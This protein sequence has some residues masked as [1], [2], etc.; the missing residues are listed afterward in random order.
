MTSQF[1][2]FPSIETFAHA[3][4]NQ[5]KRVLTAGVHPVL[6][7]LKIKLH[8]T[9]AAVRI[10]KNGE[11]T[12]Q[13]RKRD[14]TLDFDNYNFCEWVEENRAYFESLAGAEDII[15]Y[16]EWAGPGVQDTD[17]INK[18]D[19]K[20]FFPFAVQ[21]DGKLFTDTYIV[22][23]AFDT[24]LPRPDTIHILPHLAYI[25][26][27]FGRVQSIQDA[28]DEVNEIVEQIAIRDP[29][30]FAKFGIEDAGE[31][32]VGCPIYES[33]VTRQEFGELSFKAK[34]QHHRGRKAKAAASGR[35]ELTEDARQMA[36]SYITEAR[37]NQGLN[38]GL[39]GELDIRRT[40]DFLKW[41][42]GDIKKESATE[43][44]E[45]GIEWKQIAGVV[46]RLSAEWYKD[47]IAKAA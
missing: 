15:I 45:A 19:R 33:G 34:T 26:V 25:E 39:N 40:G 27:D 14:L 38:E 41:M 12:A 4:H 24:Y 5:N 17:A 28:V 47:Q 46:S 13:S 9:N 35:F 7:G 22:E 2:S 21:K 1:T 6:Y 20:M 18:I 10:D 37:L 23:A 32:V 44:E 42:G 3:V 43:L 31:G 30:V 11:I 16:G 36:L 8:G 29:Y